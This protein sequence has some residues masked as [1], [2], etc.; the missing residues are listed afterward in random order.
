[1]QPGVSLQYSSDGSSSY[2][3]YGWNLPLQSIDIETRWGVPRFDRERESES[4]LFMG[5]RLNG[6]TYRT[7]DAPARTKDRQFRPLTEGGFARIIRRGDSP[8]NLQGRN[9]IL[10]RWQGRRGG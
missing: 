8:Q 5:S 9:G 3:G 6:R 10:L 2:A 4:Y 1:M 7:A